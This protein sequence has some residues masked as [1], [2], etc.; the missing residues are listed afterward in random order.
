MGQG[1]TILLNTQE[2]FSK[3]AFGSICRVQ[4]GHQV[5][6][7]DFSLLFFSLGCFPFI[8]NNS[9]RDVYNVNLVSWVGYWGGGVF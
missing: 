3:R 8:Q 2:L 1:L 5:T 7:Q 9:T 4:A 6:T